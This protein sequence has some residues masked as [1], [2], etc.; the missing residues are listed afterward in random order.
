MIKEAISIFFMVTGTF[1][2]LLASVGMIRLPDLY[3]RLHALTKGATLGLVGILLA[4]AVSLASWEISLKV[5][6]AL[7]FH[8]LTNP[9]G[10]HMITRAAYHHLKVKFWEN[11]FAEEW[12]EDQL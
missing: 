3:T 12:K 8:F 6:L 7:F 10:A 11:T 1:F 4:S 2:M 9:V 5:V